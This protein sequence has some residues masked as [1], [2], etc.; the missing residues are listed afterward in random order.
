M[1]ALDNIVFRN[2]KPS[3]HQRVVSVM[4]NWW[5]GRDL[6]GAIL[7]VFFIHFKY[8]TFIAEKDGELL[9]FLIGFL[10]QSNPREGYIHFAGVHPDMRTLGLA[11][12][13]YKKFFEICTANNRTIVRSC[14]SPINKSSIGFHQ[15]IGFTIEPG[16]HMIDGIPVTANYLKEGDHKVLFKKILE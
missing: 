4:K 6:S 10:S 15:R 16:D 14:T 13:L 8:S 11:R 3:D 1:G 7:K 5:D 2:A 12:T 9:G